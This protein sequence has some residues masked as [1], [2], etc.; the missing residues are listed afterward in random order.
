MIAETGYFTAKHESYADFREGQDLESAEMM[1][2]DII[3][4]TAHVQ[5]AHKWLPLLARHA[6][7]DV[8]G[9]RERG[10]K[11]RE[12]YQA[13][14]NARAAEC[15]Q[16]LPRSPGDPTYDLYQSLLA[17]F[18]SVIPLANAATCPPRSPRPM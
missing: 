16:T 4:E 2:F 1:L 13:R 14:A 8:S 6:G 5:Y 10:V 18:R 15:M 12:E 9:Y 17:R 3:D 11:V 7:V